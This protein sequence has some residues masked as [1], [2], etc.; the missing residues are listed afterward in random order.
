[1]EA[2]F[3]PCEISILIWLDLFKLLRGTVIAGLGAS[4]CIAGIISSSCYLNPNSRLSIVSTFITVYCSIF[5]D[6]QQI[7]FP[8]VTFPAEDA[9]IGWGIFEVIGLFWKNSFLDHA[10]HLGGLA[11]GLVYTKWLIERGE[12][13]RNSSSSSRF[14]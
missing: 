8:F 12:V 6:S 11:T 10:A 2:P 7:I 4:G 9:L 14:K 5:Y 13:R 1:M 3:G